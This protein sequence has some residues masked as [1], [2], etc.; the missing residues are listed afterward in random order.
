MTFPSPLPAELAVLLTD[1]DAAPFWE[2]TRQRRLCF[3]QCSDCGTF[4]QPPGPLCP[5]CRSRATTWTE[6]PGAGTVFTF[7]TVVHP[8]HPAVVDFVP[9]LVALIEF[10]DVPGIRLVSNLVEVEPGAVSIGM[11]VEVAWDEMSD[12]VVIPRF[13]PAA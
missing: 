11:S 5:N 4:R 2:M 3:Q 10:P 1:D 12:E 9:Y 8:V 6:T 7:T 13:R